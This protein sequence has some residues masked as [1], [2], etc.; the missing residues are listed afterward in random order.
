MWVAM[1]D[2][3][4]SIVQD[5]LLAD[6]LVVRARV[7]E[8]LIA[9]M[10]DIEEDKIIETEDSDYRFRVFTSKEDVAYL[11]SDRVMDIHYDNFKNSV[12]ETWRST[13]YL[14]IWMIMNTVQETIYGSPWTNYRA[15]WLP[16]KGDR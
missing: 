8:D 10:P 6:G 11:I 5:R 14:K 13:A 1:N 2:S 16:G 7:K 15:Y 3:F 4:V 12:K 9:F